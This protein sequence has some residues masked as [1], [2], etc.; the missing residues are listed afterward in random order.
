MIFWIAGALFT[1]GIL[2][3][4]EEESTKKRTP[5]YVYTVTMFLWPFALG[6]FFYDMVK[7]EREKGDK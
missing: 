5:W 6:F 1:L 3:S 2:C 4:E 7:N